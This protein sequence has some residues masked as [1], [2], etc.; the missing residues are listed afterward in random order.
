MTRHQFANTM[1]TRPIFTSYKQE[2]GLALAASALDDAY[3]E[4]LRLTDPQGFWNP[5]IPA[6]S[7]TA[8]VLK[9]KD[10]T[11][12][13]TYIKMIEFFFEFDIKHMKGRRTYITAL[14]GKADGLLSA[15]LKNMAE[16][17][18]NYYHPHAHA[19]VKGRP[20]V[21][22][23]TG[24][25]LNTGKGLSWVTYSVKGDKSAFRDNLLRMARYD[26]SFPLGTNRNL[27]FAA[28]EKLVPHSPAYRGWNNTATQQKYPSNLGGTKILDE[29][30]AELAAK[31]MP[32]QGNDRW[33]DLAL[34]VFGSIMTVQA[35][36]DGNKR[37]SRFAYV[38]VLLS[39]GV[40]ILVPNNVFGSQLGDMM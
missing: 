2:V 8:Q 18:G 16:P 35:F 37:M 4:S 34:Y 19:E 25:M 17:E 12:L 7:A 3:S 24:D 11:A 23:K 40:P 13:S 14:K 6:H 26:G 28:Y 30:L 36:T 10:D 38:L 1:R 9:F 39:G 20:A 21:P 5:G 27:L 15:T 29:V 31:T 22:E 32:R 33:Y